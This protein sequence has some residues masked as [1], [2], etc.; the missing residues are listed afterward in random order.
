MI[1]TGAGAATLLAELHAAC[2]SPAEAWDEG[3]MA[4]LLATPGC[5]AV[6][7]GAEPEGLGLAL[8]RVAADEV[9]LLLIGVPP[10]M[11]RRG[12]ARS[13]LA[14]L[15]DEAISRG[16]RSLFLEVSVSNGPALALYRGA[17]FAVVGRRRRYYPDG[18]DALVLGRPCRPENP[19]AT[20]VASTV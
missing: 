3:A 2:V 5:F 12:V 1:L 14:E 18:G 15:A 7:A 6:V 4:T 19:V 16:A 13:L 20:A 17:G 10:R 11:R 9:E 8:A